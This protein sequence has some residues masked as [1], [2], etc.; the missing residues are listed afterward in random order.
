MSESFYRLA[1]FIQEFIYREKWEALRSFQIDT[2][3]AVLDT[4]DHILI[5][6]GTASGKTEAAFL[7]ILTDLYER[8]STSIGAMY[9]GPLKALINDQFYRLDAL[10]EESDLPVQSW[11][12][13]VGQSKKSRFLK[14][15]KGILQIT[16]E[17]LEAMIM[18]RQTE[19]RR[20]FGDLRY[21]VIDEAHA[22]IDSDR[23]RQVMCQLQRLA[24]YQ[25]KPTR[26]IGLSA[27]LGEPEIAK[28]WLVGGTDYGVIHINDGV[29]GREVQLG[30][31]HFILADKDE[32]EDIEREEDATPN[33]P[34]VDQKDDLFQHMYRIVQ[35]ANKTLI[36]ANSRGDVEACIQ[37]LRRLAGK[38]IDDEDGYYVHHGSVSAALRERAEL[39]MRD[40]DKKACVAATITLELGIDLGS[41]D[42]VLQLNPPSTVAS[43]VQRLG[44]SGRRGS[45]AK[46]FFYTNETDPDDN[47]TLGRR[48]PWALLQTIAIIQ[49]YIEDKWIEPPH[50]PKLPLS[51]L[52]HQTMS[53]IHA[54][55]ELSPR[56]LAE[57]ILTLSPFSNVTLDQY[58]TLLQYLIEMDHLERIEGGGLII[59][60]AAEK[61]VNHYHF[62]ATFES[63]IACQVREG[64]REIGT[65]QSLPAPGDRFRLAGRSW[66]V[67][68]IDEERR[69]IQ[70]QLVRGKATAKWMGSG[71]II[72]TRIL[73]RMR[74]ILQETNDYGY[75]QLRALER[76]SQVRRLAQSTGLVSKSILPLGGGDFML[77]PWQGTRIIHTISLLFKHMG[78]KVN[79]VETPYYLNVKADNEKHLRSVIH[80]IVENVPDPADVV[81]SLD[82]YSMFKNKYDR[83]VPNELLREA[84]IHDHMD[85]D[86]AI[87]V[88][89][90]MID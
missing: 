64:S 17:S 80:E 49:L 26:R 25:T 22:F 10:L 19:L 35:N 53:S 82:A 79:D 62:Y 6:S 24:R 54:Q 83:Y 14:Q 55:T 72:H 68:E 11:H 86:T 84:Y 9:I 5:T 90:E 52:Y 2:I 69:I 75:L 13:D 48:I 20:L 88:L 27:T 21:V 12:G 41:L 77:V 37:N 58:R 23:G 40:P 1:P 51:L 44:R 34:I 70:V 31:E 60:H 30:L 4:T 89:A 78:L 36:F 57:H 38:E 46:M 45:S 15:A 18:N 65:I 43:F 74:Q 81:S 56:H 61:M 3:H 7:P 47:V 59:G 71:V 66:E 63:E 73:Q 67:L 50:I 16:P 76:L 42:Q 33:T 32:D 29:K 87:T 28:S 8:P 39:D 85:M